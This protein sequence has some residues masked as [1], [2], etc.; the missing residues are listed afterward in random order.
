[1][2]Y[3][4]LTESEL[5]ILEQVSKKTGTDYEINNSLLPLNNF[6]SVI[7]DL[8]CEIGTLEE[9]IEYLEK[10]IEDNYISRP[11]SDYTGDSYD[12]RF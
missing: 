6:M 12:D 7:E 5:K 10:D 1:M 3:K 8:L 2:F 9:K 4:V 11:R